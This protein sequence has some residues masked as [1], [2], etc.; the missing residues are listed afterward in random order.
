[1]SPAA[2]NKIKSCS[3]GGDRRHH[4]EVDKFSGALQKGIHAEA[5]IIEDILE[6]GRL[7]D[8]EDSNIRLES[9]RRLNPDCMD[10]GKGARYL[11][12]PR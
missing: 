4:T 3:H 12:C 9:W 5:D 10:E 11:A 2:P 7:G 1:M 8:D 6:P